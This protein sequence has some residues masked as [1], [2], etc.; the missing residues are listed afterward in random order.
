MLRKFKFHWILTRI[1]RILHAYL[2]TLGAWGGVV[3]KVLRYLLEGL[4]IDPQWC[5]WGFFSEAPT[6][7]CALGSTQP[8]KMST[9]KTPGGKGGR[10][11]RVTT[12]PPLQYRKSRKSG[13]L[14]LPGPQGPVAGKLYLYLCTFM[15]ISRWIFL[16]IRSISG[17][18]FAE[19]IKIHILFSTNF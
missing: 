13:S 15:I 14:N 1:L 9:R 17:K 18:S 4:G 2:W 16:I 6:E 10:C 7:L 12:L 3:V 5:R 8:L 19:K 11:V